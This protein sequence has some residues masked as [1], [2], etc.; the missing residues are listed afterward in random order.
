MTDLTEIK[1]TSFVRRAPSKGFVAAIFP[2][3]PWGNEVI[4][5][6]REREEAGLEASAHVGTDSS[7]TEFVNLTVGNALVVMDMATAEE[8]CNC[9][10]FHQME[11]RHEEE[12]ASGR[13]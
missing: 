13:A 1:L 5:S 2:E 7:G 4:L 3:V 10:R 6:L 9:L 11:Q 8:V 12:E